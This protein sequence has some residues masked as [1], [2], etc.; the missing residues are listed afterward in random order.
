MKL[1][2]AGVA[3]TATVV[4]AITTTG[5][6]RTVVGG[7]EMYQPKAVENSLC[8]PD[9]DWGI[10][11]AGQGANDAAR[12]VDESRD[13]VAQIIAIGKERK[14]PPRAWQVAIQAGRTESGL[15]NLNYG[16]RDSLGIFQMRPS[17]GW[18]TVSQLQDIPYQIHKFYDV[19]LKV[20]N[21]E[22]RRPGDAAQAVERSAFPDR[23][24][25]WE[26]MAV[27]LIE[28]I[29]DRASFVECEQ[30]PQTSE[31][32]GTA[33]GFAMKELGKPYVW[34]AEGPNSYD[35]SGL[36]QW[37]YR[38]AGLNLP[39]TSREQWFA[40]AYVPV[41]QAQPGDLVFWAYNTNNPKTIHHVAMYLGD[42]KILEAQQTGVPVHIR[43]LKWTEGELMS[44]AVRPKSNK[45]V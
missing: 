36:M 7:N 39:R 37:S 35:C 10:G 30:L 17:M 13:I 26:S 4:V 40:G 24:H 31:T 5:V 12:L 18:G 45:R 11:G 3:L 38:L 27:H 2:L 44:M 41:R 15:R 9:L 1:V 23:Y 14:L 32:A 33:I 43:N 42:N 19:L 6:I 16:D 21:W 28:Q 22:T 29:G 20:P 34:G 25:R 8:T